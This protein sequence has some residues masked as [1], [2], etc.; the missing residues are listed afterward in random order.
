MFGVL[1][2]FFAHVQLGTVQ[3]QRSRIFTSEAAAQKNPHGLKAPHQKA[4]QA[5]LPTPKLVQY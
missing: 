2:I 5:L 3:L 1:D 4:A